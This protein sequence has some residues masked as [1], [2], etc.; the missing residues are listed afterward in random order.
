MLV[1]RMDAFW[2]HSCCRFCFRY[3]AAATKDLYVLT[4]VILLSEVAIFLLGPANH[5]ELHLSAQ[6]IESGK[7]QNVCASSHY[8]FGLC[9]SAT[10]ASGDG[11]QLHC[12]GHLCGCECFWRLRTLMTV[13]IH[14][15]KK[16]H[17][18]QEGGYPGTMNEKESL[19]HKA[20]RKALDVMIR[21]TY[22]GWPP[23]SFCG[24]YQPHRP[25]KPLPQSPR[26][27]QKQGSTLIPLCFA[28][29]HTVKVWRAFCNPQSYQ[30][31]PGSRISY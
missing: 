28:P 4:T 10:G 2:F 11:C 22:D 12:D 7:T 19:M 20:T 3:F 29:R 31:S 5:P 27:W 9:C 6:R 18:N 23:N 30:P 21:R 13:E 8:V 17:V 14:R 26:E 25:E 1:H 15:F 24:V 16:E